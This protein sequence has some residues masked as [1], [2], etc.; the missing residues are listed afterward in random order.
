VFRLVDVERVIPPAVTVISH[1]KDR[2]DTLLASN[3]SKK[4]KPAESTKPESYVYDPSTVVAPD[5]IPLGVPKTVPVKLNVIGA[6]LAT[7][8]SNIETYALRVPNRR[9][10]F[11]AISP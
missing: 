9:D 3:D 4:L 1:E 10:F 7:E 2:L 5:H 6:A 8:T 11:I